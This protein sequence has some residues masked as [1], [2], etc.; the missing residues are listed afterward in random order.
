MARP[1]RPFPSRPYR[2]KPKSSPRDGA[3]LGALGEMRDADKDDW[4][5]IGGIVLA[6]VIGFTL[7]GIYSAKKRRR[8]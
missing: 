7:Y 4:K 3:A 6:L 5:V 2:A 1:I 8:Q